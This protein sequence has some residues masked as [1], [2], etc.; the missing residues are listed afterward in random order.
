MN[1]CENGTN[2]CDE[3]RGICTEFNNESVRRFREKARNPGC[4]E[5][6]QEMRDDEIG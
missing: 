6:G 4:H 5:S 2:V 1:L 3:C